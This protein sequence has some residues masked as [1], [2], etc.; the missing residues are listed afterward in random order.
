MKGSDPPSS[1]TLF[2]SAWPAV[3]GDRHAG[4][5]APGQRDGG[6][7]R[8]L[9]DLGDVLGLDEQ[10]GED[11]LGQPGPPEQVLDGKGG[12]RHV[13]GV[14]EQ[15]DVADHE[16]RRGEADDLPHGEVPGHDRP[17]P[18]RSAGS[19]RTDFERRGGDRL[20]GQQ[21]L[22]VLGEPAQADSALGHLRLGGGEGLAHLG[23]HD[24]G[25]IGDLALEQL[26]RGRPGGGPARRRWSSCSR[27]MRRRRGRRMASTSAGVCGG[28][29]LLRLA[30][31]GVRWWQRAWHRV[32]PRCFQPQVQ[33][34]T[35]AASACRW[36]CAAS[37]RR[38]SRPWAACT[39]AR[40]ADAAARRASSASVGAVRLGDE[41]SAHRLAPL[42]VGQP[43]HRQLG[44]PA[45]ADSTFSTSAG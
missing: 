31:G 7:A 44:T 45:T 24:A 43:E 4:P 35:P 1:S 33:S 29:R 13:R 3:G 20:V 2:F 41:G 16:R 21:R 34:G 11:A 25:D 28:E 22:A 23:G 18:R 15:A 38:R 36:R 26:G 27:R 39:G 37:R 32:L 19:A 5:L 12:L 30:G 14:L 40:W 17:A 10:V 8:V 42:L 6:D 9:D